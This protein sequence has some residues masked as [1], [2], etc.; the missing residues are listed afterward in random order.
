MAPNVNRPVDEK[1]READ[2]NRKLQ[3]YGVFS[4]FKAGK[5][6]SNEQIDVALNTFL[7][8]KSLAVP[9]EKLSPE[10]RE[11]VKEFREVVTQAQYLLLCKNEGNL[12]QDFIWQ[13]KQFD[14]TA[15]TPP[16]DAPVNKELAQHHGNQALEGL[17]TLGTLII[18]N[19]QFRK[20]LKDATILLRDIAG[21]AA[22][23][24]AS[25]VRP[26][27][28]DLSQ[29]DL[30]AED[31][32]W[33]DAPDLSKDKVKGKFHEY[34]KGDPRQDIKVAAAQGTTSQGETNGP[35]AAAEGT[36]LA[37]SR[38][39]VKQKLTENIDE[40]T[41]E[42]A[43]ARSEEYGE[44][45]RN[46]FNR[47]MPQELREQVV[48][49]LKK[50][51]LECQQ[52]PDYYRAIQTLLGLAEQYGDHATR[53]ARGSSDTVK[54]A[55]S[56]L[57]RAERDLRTLIERFANGTSTSDLWNSIRAIY[58]DADNDPRLKRWFKEINSY[59]HRCL[60]EQGFIL[61]DESNDEWNELYDEGRYLLRDRYRGHTDRIVDEVRF[62]ADQ[63]EQDSQNKAFAASLSKLF[64]RLGNDENGKPTFKAHLLRDL[65]HI[66]IPA[67]LERIAYVPLPRIEY[68]DK[69]VDAIIENLVL[70]SDNFMPNVLEVASENYMR[71]GRKDVA[72]R[73]RHSVDV[74]VAGIQLD[75]RDVSYYIR[76][77]RGFPALTD[78]GVA[79][80]L[81]AG[82]GFTFR[83]RLSSPD[84]H[85]GD[86]K[87]KSS[88]FRVDKVDVTVHNLRVKLIQSQHKL[89]FNLFKP[90]LLR[91]LRPVLQNTLE[92]AIRDQAAEIDSLLFE[93]KQEADRARQAAFS[94]RLRP[95]EEGQSLRAAPN[96]Y[97]RY[98]AAV[99]RRIL[100]RGKEKA[101]AAAAAAAAAERKINYAVTRED[102]IFP[103]IHLPGGFSDKATE[104]RRLAREGD[105]WESPAFSIGTAAPSTDVPPAPKI[106]KKS[107]P[108]VVGSTAAKGKQPQPQHPQPQHP[109][110]QHP[111]PQHP[112]PQQSHYPQQQQPQHQPSLQQ[113]P[114]QSHYPQQQQPQHQPSP[115]QQLQQSH[116]P[117]QQQPQHQQS[118]LQQPLPQDQQHLAPAPDKTIRGSRDSGVAVV[119][120]GG[121][122]VHNNAANGGEAALR[123][124]NL[125]EGFKAQ[126]PAFDPTT[127]AT[128]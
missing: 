18:T 52:H 121:P 46:Y 90:L 17:R 108:R 89:L 2:V 15:L 125:N 36:N 39:A 57:L 3:V 32:T 75:L 86:K 70:E 104:L 11:L 16:P 88:F 76:R 62:L 98:A 56:A 110:P 27:Q 26:S 102:S 65:T 123:Q 112:Q 55:H 127:T 68:S 29:I 72:S 93:V 38:D 100:L 25:T 22:T 35:Q 92:K 115:Q 51:I 81:L 64:T 83:I 67:A 85:D 31:N 74:K 60:E 97:R 117:Q 82:D 114:Q 48:W 4:A 54:D 96:A 77:K 105:G 24:V 59:V 19:G 6:P 43:K 119:D 120:V 49:R 21:D 113:Q 47:K 122:A 37:T 71:F 99:Q 61:E 8:S 79:N 10:G 20:L 111:Q 14:P 91:V 45:A 33:Y 9:S 84:G 42:K 30:P 58:D 107:H 53:L 118:L 63:F 128:Y 124:R 44:R 103:E 95:D 78:K 7:E 87:A 109:Q 101:R 94:R 5:V 23:H 1:Q 28:E 41:K 80:F 12:L 106:V 50:M 69:D 40:E 34:Y 126:M 13:T 66:V 73:Q 116:Y